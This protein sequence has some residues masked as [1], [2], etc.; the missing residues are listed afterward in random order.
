M[1]FIANTFI[2]IVQ[3]RQHKFFKNDNT[4]WLL[5]PSTLDCPISPISV[6]GKNINVGLSDSRERESVHLD[7]S[8]EPKCGPITGILS[9]A[10][11]QMSL[12]R[13]EGVCY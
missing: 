9:M 8:C 12:P 1:R 7:Q 10:M 13:V 11:G 2:S 6:G 5:G 3:P 4:L